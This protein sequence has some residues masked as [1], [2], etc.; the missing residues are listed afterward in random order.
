LETVRKEGKMP[1]YEY[2]CTK[3]N[4]EFELMRPFSEADKPAIC[5]KCNSD[6]QKVVSGFA[7][8]TGA[9][10]QVSPKPFRKGV[11]ERVE[12]Y[13]QPAD[14]E[15]NMQERPMTKQKRYPHLLKEYEKYLRQRERDGWITERTRKHYLN[16]AQRVMEALVAALPAED[17]QAKVG[18]LY[19]GYYKNIIKELKAI[20]ER[21]P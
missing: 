7:C 19:R 6:G 5:P 4:T 8:K 10:L 13:P 14:L 1:V 15:E 20:I 12:Q 16:D 11:P 21:R 17:I 18:L 2:V 9:C 3:C